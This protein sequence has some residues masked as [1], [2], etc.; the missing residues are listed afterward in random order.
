MTDY[1]RDNDGDLLVVNGDFVRGESTAEHQRS[2]LLDNKGEYKQNP[3][4]CVGVLNYI[5]DDTNA[6]PREI[7]KEFMADG[8]EVSNLKVEQAG[9]QDNTVKIFPGAYYK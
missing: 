8:M 2:L 7:V 5:D 4:A 6:L 9:W 3:T 1:L